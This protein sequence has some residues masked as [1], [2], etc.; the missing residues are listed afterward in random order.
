[1]K[2][3]L[4]KRVV[5]LMGPAKEPNAPIFLYQKPGGEGNNGTL[6]FYN[7]IHNPP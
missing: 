1:M 5:I 7:D 6:I 3:P 4:F 2:I